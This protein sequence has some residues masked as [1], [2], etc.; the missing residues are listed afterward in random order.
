M[1]KLR[2]KQRL[3]AVRLNL[4]R[5]STIPRPGQP[6]SATNPVEIPSVVDLCYRAI[7]R[8]ELWHT[9]QAKRGW[10]YIYLEP[11]SCHS[12]S[13]CP[14]LTKHLERV[15]CP[16]IRRTRR[17]ALLD[18]PKL[19]EVLAVTIG[20]FILG[21]Y[22]YSR[23][24]TATFY[25][26][27]TTDRNNVN[28]LLPSLGIWSKT[29]LPKRAYPLIFCGVSRQQRLFTPLLTTGSRTDKV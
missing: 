22:I 21:V 4:G 3:Q 8:D 19:A 20:G 1:D 5:K 9:T 26:Q 24:F 11:W 17:V 12:L 15:N 23:S 13:H 10:R 25:H 18:T 29:S 6:H 14:L 27:N 2:A 16:Q 28:N 7:P